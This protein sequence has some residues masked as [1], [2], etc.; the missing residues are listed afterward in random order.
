MSRSFNSAQFRLFRVSLGVIGSDYDHMVG[1][2]RPG[3]QQATYQGGI[4]RPV[5]PR[6][7]GGIWSTYSR[8]PAAKPLGEQAAGWS[9]FGADSDVMVFP[10]CQVATP[11]LGRGGCKSLLPICRLARAST[12]TAKDVLSLGVH[13]RGGG[14]PARI[15]VIL[16]E[17]TVVG[18]HVSYGAFANPRNGGCGWRYLFEQVDLCARQA[19]SMRIRGCRPHSGRSFDLHM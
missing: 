16:A 8:G 11:P 3:R 15:I 18:G 1:A 7:G 13:G 19:V 12:D 5:A 4:C 17:I 14:F 10:G 6:R 2:S 9:G